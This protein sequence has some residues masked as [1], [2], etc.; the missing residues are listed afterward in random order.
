MSTIHRTYPDA[1]GNPGRSVCGKQMGPNAKWR[2]TH[3]PNCPDCNRMSG[4]GTPQ[5]QRA[6]R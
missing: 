2:H 5:R 3:M 4:Q 6:R 1:D